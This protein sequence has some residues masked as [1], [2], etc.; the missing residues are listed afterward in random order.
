MRKEA[1]ANVLDYCAGLFVA[2]DVGPLTWGAL[3]DCEPMPTL[4]EGSS[5]EVVRSL[6]SSLPPLGFT[7]AV[8]ADYA[9]VLIL[10]QQPRDADNLDVPLLPAHRRIIALR[11]VVVVV[12]EWQLPALQREEHD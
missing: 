7:V 2:R 11:P 6:Q 12:G 8:V 10:E 9:V 4:Q 3:P 5:G 1:S